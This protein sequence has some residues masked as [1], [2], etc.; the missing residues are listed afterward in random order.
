MLIILLGLLM[1]LS[2]EAQLFRKHKKQESDSLKNGVHYE[3]W[4]KDSTFLSARGHFRHG[5]PC[6]TWKYYHKSG[7]RR[8]KVKYRDRLKIKYYRDSGKLDQKGYAILDLDSEVIHFYW[9]GIWKYYD[10]KRK[11]Y[12]IA[13][14]QNG[15]EVE[16]LKGPTDPIY[17]E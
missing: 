7:K 5:R 2:S 16:V 10:D 11:L 14:Y 4:D 8:M 15:E 3:Y 12:R 17:F 9:H 6:K 1:P 13:L